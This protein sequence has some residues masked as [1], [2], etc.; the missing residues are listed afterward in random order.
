MPNCNCLILQQLGRIAAIAAVAENHHRGCDESTR[1]VI[2][3][4]EGPLLLA[5][6]EGT[7]GIQF[8]ARGDRRIRTCG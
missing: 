2:R 1:I 8:T 4:Y 5:V 3:R 7:S 6:V